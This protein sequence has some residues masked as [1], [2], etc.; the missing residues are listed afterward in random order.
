MM[1]SSLRL[2]STKD[3]GIVALQVFL[4]QKGEREREREREK[5]KSVPALN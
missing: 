5:G 2:T 4:T 3:L 1:R